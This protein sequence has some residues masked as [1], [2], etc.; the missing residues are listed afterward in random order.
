MRRRVVL[1]VVTAVLIAG[2]ITLYDELTNGDESRHSAGRTLNISWFVYRDV[3]R[4]GVYDVADRPYAG[5]PVALRRP[6]GETRLTTS[7][8]NGFANFSMGWQREDAD[9]VGPG[10]YSMHAYVTEPWQVTTANDRIPLAFRRLKGSPAG[11]VAE[12]TPRPL[13]LAPA[14]MIRGTLDTSHGLEELTA[15]SPSG[16]KRPVDL[17]PDGSFRIDG[18]PGRWMIS[19][20]S[21]NPRSRVK[22]VIELDYYPVVVSRSYVSPDTTRKRASAATREVTAGYDDL[23]GA[24]SLIKIPNGYHGLSWRNWI[25]THQYFYNGPG[26]VNAAVSA[27]YVAYTSSGHPG[28]ISSETPFDF[29]GTYIGVAWRPAG[30]GMVRI[31]GFR[32]GERLYHDELALT[33]DLPVYFL[34]GYEG[35]TRLEIH[36]D[37]YWQVILEDSRFRVVGN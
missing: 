34:A 4:N 6:D 27:E 28:Q 17:A 9:I 19:A 10:A 33:S 24:D 30:D 35:I 18:K 7:N 14:P 25:A 13:G 21:R 36:S 5:L 32:D 12:A 16:E 15:E 20:Y 3:N 31:E 1:I 37:I 29:V 11:L 8:I 26:Y 2:A 23:T 22:K